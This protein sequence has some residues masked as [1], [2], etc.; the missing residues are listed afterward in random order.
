MLA[1]RHTFTTPGA[2]SCVNSGEYLGMARGAKHH[3][4]PE[5]VELVPHLAQFL[6]MKLLVGGQALL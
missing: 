6:R 5:D 4:P 3:L 2:G 1:H